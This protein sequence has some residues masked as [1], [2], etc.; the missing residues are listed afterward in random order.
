MEYWPV[1]GKL[2]LLYLPWA[3]FKSAWLNRSYPGGVGYLLEG[4]VLG[5]SALHAKFCEVL[6]E[7]YAACPV[8]GS[9]T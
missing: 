1:Q 8:C 9:G 7:R 3:M 6:V 5:C 4:K 2:S